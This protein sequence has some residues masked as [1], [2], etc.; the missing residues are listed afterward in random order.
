MNIF[1]PSVVDS[2]IERPGCKPPQYDAFN[3]IHRSL[4]YDGVHRELASARTG[5]V[6][7]GEAGRLPVSEIVLKYRG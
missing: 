3:G 7:F 5:G 6:N 1:P 4:A 2:H